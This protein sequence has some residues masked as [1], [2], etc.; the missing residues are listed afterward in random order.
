MAQRR[1][2]LNK[3]H[4]NFK[5]MKRFSIFK[6]DLDKFKKGDLIPAKFFIGDETPALYLGWK[7]KKLIFYFIKYNKIS[8]D[9][10]QMKLMGEPAEIMYFIGF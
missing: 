7:N 10:S 9:F 6:S 2:R 3:K 5:S 4:K 8:N 1:C